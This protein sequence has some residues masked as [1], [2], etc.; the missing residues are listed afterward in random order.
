MGKSTLAHLRDKLPT[1]HFSP[2][3]HGCRM[4][5]RYMGAPVRVGVYKHHTA[6]TWISH[7]TVEYVTTSDDE[8]VSMI[9]EVLCKEAHLCKDEAHL[10]VASEDE[11]PALRP[12]RMKVLTL[13]IL[14]GEGMASRLSDL[15]KNAQDL[16]VK[17]QSQLDGVMVSVEGLSQTLKDLT[18][19]D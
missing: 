1:L 4:I 19:S 10:K 15:I 14:R 18:E 7:E 8:I 3:D 16:I 5:G 12:L 9:V 6:V 17:Y 2:G 13:R 11:T